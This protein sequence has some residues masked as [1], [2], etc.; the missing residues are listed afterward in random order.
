MPD[1]ESF[2]ARHG[3]PV[4]QALIENIER[5]SGVRLR[6]G[7]PLEQRWHDAM[8]GALAQENTKAVKP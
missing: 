4:T 3:E 5:H 2:V 6:L 8:S 7:L 1:F